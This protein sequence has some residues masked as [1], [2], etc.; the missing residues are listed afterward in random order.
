MS[1]RRGTRA[2]PLPSS[3][4]L[5]RRSYPTLC[6]YVRIRFKTALPMC[7][8]LFKNLLL[9]GLVCLAQLARTVFPCVVAENSQLGLTAENLANWFY[10]SRELQRAN[11]SN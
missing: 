6:F 2:A 3:L 7:S 9:S 4:R 5:R 1:R 10:A 8:A 11:S